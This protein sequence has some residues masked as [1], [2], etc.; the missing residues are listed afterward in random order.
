MGHFIEILDSASEGIKLLPPTE[1]TNP[2]HKQYYK[3][4]LSANFHK[5]MLSTFMVDFSKLLSTSI[6]AAFSKCYTFF[7]WVKGREKYII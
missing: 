6:F 4:C 3:Y 5:W 2:N 1:P 7:I